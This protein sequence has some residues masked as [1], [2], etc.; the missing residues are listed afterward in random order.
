MYNQ[1]YPYMMGA[2]PNATRMAS[3]LM[4]GAL[5]TSPL[6]SLLGARSAAPAVSALGGAT[7]AS[8]F[9]FSGLLNGAS[10][11]LGVIN[12][13]I[14]IFYQVKPIINN[15]KTMY[16]V[17]KEINSNDRKNTSTNSSNNNSNNNTK[18]NNV[19]NNNDVNK[20]NFFI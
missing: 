2:V 19:S 12:Q 7:K 14:P 15:A 16:R 20:P 17:A 6:S 11:T 4:G 3:P 10:K 8:T 13:A 1:F 5:R 9:T 18:T